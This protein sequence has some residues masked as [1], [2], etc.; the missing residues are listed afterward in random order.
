MCQ[1]ELGHGIGLE[2]EEG[3]R[4]WKEV[5]WEPE[6]GNVLCIGLKA[7]IPGKCSVRLQDMVILNKDG[8]RVIGD[9]CSAELIEVE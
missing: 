6:A 7:G 3:I 2:E 9:T 4:I 5:A 1:E 8:V